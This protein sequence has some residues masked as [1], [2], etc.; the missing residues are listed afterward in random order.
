[1]AIGEFCNRDVVI[2]ARN[3]S[4]MQAAQL[5]RQFHVGD[6][7]VTEERNGSRVPIGILTDRDL[8][9][10]V[11]A[12]NVAADSVNVGDVMSPEIITARESDGIYETIQ[13]MRTNGVRR[14][15]VVNERGG[16]EGII[17]VD[18]LLGLLAEEITGL[19][20]LVMREQARERSNRR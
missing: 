14:I 7:V 6:L 4:I 12:E 10:E 20:N 9:V 16:L 11:L 18:D 8:V 1:M 2:V 17:A 15:P 3:S 13:R 5:M 19:A